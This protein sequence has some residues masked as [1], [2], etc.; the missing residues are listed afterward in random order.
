MVPREEQDV[1]SKVAFAMEGGKSC[2]SYRVI[3]EISLGYFLVVVH[4]MSKGT[5]SGGPT[6]S[7]T[8]VGLG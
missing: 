2:G 7:D 3:V 5:R 1:E 6:Y 8:Y 4:I